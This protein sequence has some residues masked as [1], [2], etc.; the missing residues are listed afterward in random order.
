MPLM[1]GSFKFTFHTPVGAITAS[2]IIERQS[3]AHLP[4]IDMVPLIYSLRKGHSRART[5]HAGPQLP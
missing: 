4:V 2:T 5:M 3:A 1:E